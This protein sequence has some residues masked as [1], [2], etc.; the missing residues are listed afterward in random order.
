M[1][2]DESVELL[3]EEADTRLGPRVPAWVKSAAVEGA[4]YRLL[5]HCWKNLTD[6]IGTERQV[7]VVLKEHEWLVNAM[8]EAQILT[9]VH[10]EYVMPMAYREAPEHIK[11]QWRNR[12]TG[13]DREEV[14]QRAA[15]VAAAQRKF[16]NTADPEP[17]PAEEPPLLVEGVN[18]FG[19]VEPEPPKKA[20]PQKKVH[21]P[22][23]HRVIEHW[24]D[25]YEEHYGQTP[26][27]T[28]KD[29]GHLKAALKAFGGDPARTCDAL[30]NYLADESPF[31]RGHPLGIWIA[32]L[33]KWAAPRRA[34]SGSAHQLAE[35]IAPKEL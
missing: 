4:V 17:L 1:D 22:L 6:T 8:A 20:R 7:A 18:L 10:G 23:V 21:Q 12:V 28:N 15:K 35:S 25:R 9:S 29:A 14:K 26:A 30:D 5:R 33:N 16:F 11:R 3:R 34:V 32:Q 31:V 24:H 2:Y 27:F 19:E 13:A